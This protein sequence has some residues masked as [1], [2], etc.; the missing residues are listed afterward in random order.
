M[1]P[2]CASSRVKDKPRPGT[3][4]AGWSEALPWAVSVSSLVLAGEHGFYHQALGV[5][6]SWGIYTWPRGTEGEEPRLLR[7]C[8]R[9]GSRGK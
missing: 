5:L 3:L 6:H 9:T 8:M 7:V 1:V 4:G 2:T